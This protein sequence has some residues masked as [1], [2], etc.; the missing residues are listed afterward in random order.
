MTESRALKKV[1]AEIGSVALQATVDDTTP[2]RREAML[3]AWAAGWSFQEVADHWGIQSAAQAA[4]TIER[5][6]AESDLEGL[7]R[8]KERARFTKSLMMHHSVAAENAHDAESP[9]Q[10]AWM[11]MDL[12][13]IDRLIR[14]RGLDAPTQIV[15]SPGV[16]EFERLTNLI[17]LKQGADTSVE[18]DP[19][20]EAG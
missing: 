13:I 11:R 12:I 20:A 9:E 3:K 14:L 2:T 17:A 16:E 15:V 5:A 10:L 1:K 6:L 18:F 8:E 7:D 4:A 19:M